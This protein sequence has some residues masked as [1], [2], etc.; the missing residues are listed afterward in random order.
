MA[1]RRTGQPGGGRW[2]GQS[3]LAGLGLAAAVL[4]VVGGLG[5]W[6][7]AFGLVSVSGT[8]GD[9]WLV[10]AAGVIGGASLLIYASRPRAWAAVVAGLAGAGGAVVSGIDL[11][12]LAGA[13]S[14]SFFDQRVRLVEP[15]WGIYLSVGAS[16]ALALL[17]LA[18]LA[19][20]AVGA[21]GT[22]RGPH[23]ATVPRR[24]R[25]S[26]SASLAAFAIAA[27][28][29]ATVLLS[30]PGRNS[31]PSSRGS[32]ATSAVQTGAPTTFTP[33]RH[34][35]GQAQ[36]N[37][38][39]TFDLAIDIGKRLKATNAVP[40]E[41]STIAD[42]CTINK[43]RDI[44]VPMRLALT[45]TNGGGSSETIATGLAFRGLQ[46]AGP[47][48]LTVEIA[49]S[50]STKV[51]VGGATHYTPGTECNSVRG[52]SHLLE[53]IADQ[54]VPAGAHRVHDFLV[55]VRN[56][57]TPTNPTGRTADLAKISARLYHTRLSCF[58]GRGGSSGRFKLDGSPAPK[59][60]TDVGACRRPR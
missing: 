6:A 26:E 36:T 43:R 47:R 3:L 16:V 20:G 25:R 17:G 30:V 40:S 22:A 50:Y 11:H 41:F 53:P 19:V 24:R 18:I 27:A 42:A 57:Y 29:A 14:S 23:G 2:A 1:D 8:R 51:T 12:Q 37:N 59:T 33:E 32:P 7:T 38:G 31:Q 15:A 34:F 5:T 10:V 28:I 39:S 56:Y 52:T 48:A 49:S 46:S 4:A 21:V 54:R 60:A 44:V 55:V 9:G 35:Y 13:E 58:N 45:N